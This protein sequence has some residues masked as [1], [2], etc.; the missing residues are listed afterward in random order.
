M[1]GNTL[2]VVAPRFIVGAWEE[3][4]AGQQRIFTTF[5]ERVHGTAAAADP[6]GFARALWNDSAQHANAGVNPGPGRLLDQSRLTTFVGVTSMWE[7]RGVSSH[8]AA[9]TAING[10]QDRDNFRLYGEL[11]A[12]GGEE[13][14]RAFRHSIG[15]SGHGEYSVSRREQGLLGQPN[16]QFS[17]TTDLRRFDSDVD[18]RRL[19]GLDHNMKENSDVR[20]FDGGTAHLRR[21]IG[22]YGEV[23]LMLQDGLLG[24]LADVVLVG[25]AEA[26]PEAF[27]RLDVARQARSVADA[28]AERFGVTLTLDGLF[29]EMFAADAVEYIRRTGFFAALGLADGL[30]ASLTPQESANVYKRVMD[31]YYLQN[32][33]ELRT[34]FFGAVSLGERLRPTPP[35]ADAALHSV[36]QLNA[37]TGDAATEDVE[38]DTRGE[39]EEFLRAVDDAAAAYRV[40]LRAGDGSPAFYRANIRSINSQRESLFRVEPEEAWA[41]GAEPRTVYT[42]EQGVFT[43]QLVKEEA[44]LKIINLGLGN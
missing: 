32:L 23:P 33:F 34:E 41:G 16:G 8:V 35:E 4:K 22:R 15:G 28:F 13:I 31:L 24:P 37:L 38:I 17:L 21:H 36:P 5:A 19:F 30:A 42:V 39:L 29:E 43:V 6:A 14:K 44:G 27:E 25:P 1:N 3:L 26:D 10:D 20:A 9:V 12:G 40:R 7:K 11:T 2:D 18:Y